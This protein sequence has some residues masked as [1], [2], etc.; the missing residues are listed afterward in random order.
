MIKNKDKIIAVIKFSLEQKFKKYKPESENMPFHFRLLGK[1]RMALFSFIQS[2]NTTFGTSIYEPVAKELAKNHFKFVATQ[3]NLGN[4]IT[5]KA[6]ERIE[7]IINHLSTGKETNSKEEIELIRKVCQKGKINRLKITRADLFLI[8]FSNEIFLFDLKTAK[9]NINEFISYKRTLLQWTA[10]YLLKNP[11][12]KIQPIIA[13]PYNPYEPKPYVRW[14]MKGML[15]LKYEVKVAE[16]FWDFLSGKNTYS[17]LLD[18]FE[19]AGIDLR[20]KIDQYFSQ[21]K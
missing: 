11:Q 3:Y 13:I 4:E 14:T 18:C 6:Q 21:F 10:I 8:S 19:K 12:A 16:E 17:D 15:D 9:P 2:L 7:E 1:D 5:N 20:P